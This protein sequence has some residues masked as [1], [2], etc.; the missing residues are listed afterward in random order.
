MLCQFVFFKTL[1]TAEQLPTHLTL[2]TDF[3]DLLAI[4]TLV[5][6]EATTTFIFKLEIFMFVKRFTSVIYLE[7]KSALVPLPFGSGTE[8]KLVKLWCYRATRTP[9]TLFDYCP[10]HARTSVVHFHVSFQTNTCVESLLTP[11]IFALYWRFLIF[12]PIPESFVFVCTTFVHVAL[13]GPHC[14]HPFKS[15]VTD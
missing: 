15:H 9:W 12:T 3:D 13:M 6:I 4:G 2:C 11:T 1:L 5:Y 7:T 8:E 10:M 14:I